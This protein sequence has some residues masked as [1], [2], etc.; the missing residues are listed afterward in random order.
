MASIQKRV[1]KDGRVSYRVQVRLRE[2][3]TESNTFE[4]K[5]DAKKWAQQTE[6]AIRDGRHFPNSV[7]RHHSVGDLIDRYISDVLPNTIVNRVARFSYRVC[8]YH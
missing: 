4:R 7:A 2:H 1:S 5:T 3:P 8:P 6:S